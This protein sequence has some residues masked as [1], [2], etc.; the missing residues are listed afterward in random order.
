MTL[1]QRL[2]EAAEEKTREWED[3][4]LNCVIFT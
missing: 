3:F 4:R 2:I 1:K